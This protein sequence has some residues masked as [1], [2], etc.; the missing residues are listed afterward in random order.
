MSFFDLS[1]IVDNKVGALDGSVG[2]PYTAGE[3]SILDFLITG[4]YHT[5]GA[6]FVYPKYSAPIELT[7]AAA[8]WGLTGNIVEVIPE[9]AITKPFDL[10]W[11]T[12]SDI[13]ANAY[14]IIDIY[15]GLAG[16]EVLIS[17]VDS[18]KQTNFIAEGA[19][20]IQI[21]Q[22]PANT[23]ISCRLADSSANQITCNVK[24][25]GHVYGTAL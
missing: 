13:S 19:R 2:V 5:H 14:M 4:Y 17:S 23:R 9:N 18:Y 6:A 22:Q 15:A 8:V 25:N 16:A 3:N 10:H 12:I 11:I 1:K 20:V 21:P 7:S 24:F